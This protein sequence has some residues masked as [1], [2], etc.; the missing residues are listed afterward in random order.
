MSTEADKARKATAA[1]ARRIADERVAAAEAARV[2]DAE[3]QAATVARAKHLFEE[4]RS[5]VAMAS[6]EGERTTSISIMSYER[7]SY[8]DWARYLARD[9]KKLL[10]AAGFRV[11]ERTSKTVPIGS[12]PLFPWTTYDIFLQIEW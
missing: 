1:G 10:E 7:E 8:P 4:A 3:L 5:R 11:T 9:T 12:D 6:A 2:A